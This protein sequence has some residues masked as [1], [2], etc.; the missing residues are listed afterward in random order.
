MYKRGRVWSR[1]P[2]IEPEKG[3]HMA[4][5]IIQRE[6][7]TWTKFIVEADDKE[8]AIEDSENCQYLGYVDGDD[9]KLPP[10]T[11]T[12]ENSAQYLR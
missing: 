1:K 11:L 10:P 3:N 12:Q 2:I 4:W 8:S 7:K 9:T 6:R 5:F